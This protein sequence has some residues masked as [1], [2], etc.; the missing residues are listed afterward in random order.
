MDKKTFVLLHAFSFIRRTDCLNCFVAHCHRFYILWT[1]FEF[2]MNEWMIL[3]KCYFV[4]SLQAF[5]PRILG[6]YIIAAL[7]L[8]FYISKVPERYFPG[9]NTRQGLRFEF[10]TPFLAYFNMFI[11]AH[12]VPCYLHLYSQ[13]SARMNVNVQRLKK[14][15]SN[16]LETWTHFHHKL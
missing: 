8:I 3:L 4:S 10:L 9:E 14:I 13:I 12:F 2:F 1:C 7:A 5:V 16:S 15:I 11:L 6:M